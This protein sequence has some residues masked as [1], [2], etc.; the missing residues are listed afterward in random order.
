LDK[1]STAPVI[2]NID[3]FD[4]GSGSV[5]ERILFNNRPVIMI[6][7]AIITVFL[8]FEATKVRLSANYAQ[9]IPI[10]QP[11][12]VNYLNHYDVLASQSNAVQIVVVA[13]QGTILKYF[14]R[15]IQATLSQLISHHFNRTK[16]YS[17]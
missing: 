12:I 13:N 9:M 3:D 14:P 6:L 10:H 7:C 2:A 1:P 8:G 11:Y 4:K 5:V 15:L 17:L 16:L